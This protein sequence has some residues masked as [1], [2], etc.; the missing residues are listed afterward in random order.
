[1]PYWLWHGICVVPFSICPTG[2]A[3]ASSPIMG[4]HDVIH[5]TGGTQHTALSSEEDWAT[6]TVNMYRKFREIWMCTVQFFRYAR[7]QTYRHAHCN[8]LHLH[9]SRSNNQCDRN[10]NQERVKSPKCLI[11]S[12][13]I[14][15]INLIKLNLNHVWQLEMTT[16]YFQK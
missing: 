2:I 6:A 7:G 3:T 16:R 11:L 13:Q 8:I 4:K 1:M 15:N 14:M 10:L 5:K 9:R 12:S